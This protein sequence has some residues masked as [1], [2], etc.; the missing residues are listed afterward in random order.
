M[1]R[2]LSAKGRDQLI[3]NHAIC[4][5]KQMKRE[6]STSYPSHQL[7]KRQQLRSYTPHLQSNTFK[8]HILLDADAPD[9][10]TRTQNRVVKRRAWCG[11]PVEEGGIKVKTVVSV[12]AHSNELVID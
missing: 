9:I 5:G 4:L 10:N 11:R 1:L 2:P 8:A 12:S 6:S 7:T 3:E